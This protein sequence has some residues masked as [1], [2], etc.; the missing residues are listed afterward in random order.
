MPV[1]ELK[2]F[3]KPGLSES[4]AE[5]LYKL[6]KEAVVWAILEMSARWKT[7]VE[8]NPEKTSN[9]APGPNTPSGQIPVYKKPNTSSRGRKKPGRKKGH[10]GARRKE[11][12]RIDEEK[13]H[14]LDICPC[15]GE[16]LC[17]AFDQRTRITEDIPEVKPTITKHIIK[18][19]RCPKCKKVSDAPVVDAL[20]KAKIG[21]NI[22]AL[23]A[24]MHYGLGTTINQIVNV[25]N[26]HLHF[27]LT[28]GGLVNMWRR[29][30]EILDAWYEE[31]CA[32]AKDSSTLH[33]DETG[34]RVNGKTHWLWCFT[35]SN[36]TCY[37]ID[38]SR[39]SPALLKFLGETFDGTLVTD[40]WAAYNAIACDTRQYCLAHLF[41][42]IE[43]VGERNDSTQW[44]H[45]RKKLMRILRDALR[46]NDVRDITDAARASRRMRLTNRL[47]KLCATNWSDH[48][49][50]RLAKRLDK[51][52]DGIFTFLDYDDVPHT[53]NH[54]E[55]EIRPAVIMRKVLQQN[56]SDKGA[57]TQAVLMSIYRTLKMRGLDPVK[58]IIANME[59]YLLTGQLPPLPENDGSVS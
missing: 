23:T 51:Y 5:A 18:R 56:R 55:R 22:L 46:L 49:A 48:D 4:E 33:A 39:G 7:D 41:R 35:N 32:E 12:E 57:H 53:N 47:A 40:F 10:P 58:T 43:K 1:R 25:L 9:D 14:A 50:E 29:L 31:I 54:A 11:P 37:I 42:E 38:S 2:G 34:W 59:E 45:F 52:A 15:C 8:G 24:W 20:P 27:K 17:E 6:G 28:P 19:Y 21:N 36:L 30:A 16:P 13:T 3:I 26:V 44:D